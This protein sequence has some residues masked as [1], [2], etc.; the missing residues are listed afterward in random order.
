MSAA[1]KLG[2]IA[3]GDALAIAGGCIAVALNELF[4]PAEIS[5]TSGGMVTFGDM[6]LFVLATGVLGLVPTWFLLRLFVEMAPRALLTTMLLLA[7][8]GPVN[9]LAVISLAGSPPVP[10]QPQSIGA[11]AGLLPAFGAIPRIVAGPVLAVI[12]AATFLLVRGRV[13]R[14]LLAAAMPL[15]IVPLTLFVLHMASRPY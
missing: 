4:M 12:E 15:D 7:V 5:Q 11:L 6:I 14:T 3:L 10:D 2:L 8:L 13:A 9:W 1:K